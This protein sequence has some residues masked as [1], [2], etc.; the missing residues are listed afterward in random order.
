MKQA[1]DV[2]FGTTSDSRADTIVEFN[3]KSGKITDFY[4][5]ENKIADLTSKCHFYASF[6]AV[7]NQHHTLRVVVIL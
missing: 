6:K 7:L 2:K 4:D 5:I 3:P 1:G